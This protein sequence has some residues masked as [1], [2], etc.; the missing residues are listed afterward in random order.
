MKSFFNRFFGNKENKAAGNSVAKEMLEPIQVTPTLTLPKALADYFDYI[1]PSARHTVAI[2]AT[3]AT[4]LELRQSKFGHYPCIPKGF[5]Y[6]K[7]KEGNFLYPLAQL[8]LSEVP[9]LDNFPSSGYLQFYIATDDT[10]GLSFEKHVP[11]NF[12]V[13]FFEEAELQT[14]EEDMSFLDN[15]LN[16]GHSP[17]EE[18]HALQ[19]ELKTEYVGLGDVK[20]GSEAGF[21]LDG[22]LKA[23]PTIKR[24]L[25][26]AA[27]HHFSPTGHKLGG[28]AYFTQWDP[29]DDKGPEKDY[30][31]LFQMDSDN[32][33]LWGDVGVANF[34]I[35]PTDLANKDF[36]KVLYNWDCH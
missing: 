17:V 4:S 7:D 14:P 28:Y 23:N 5:D 8:N 24:E 35:D 2:K 1:E 18:P 26:S 9:H 25:E 19:F 12:K 31:L 29:R 32:H 33:I 3:P 22:L 27:F 21:D 36:S 34:F 10:Y 30:L 6:P 20:G 16:N 15:V 11:S 13:L